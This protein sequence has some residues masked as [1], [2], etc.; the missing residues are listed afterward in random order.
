MSKK[1]VKTEE[2]KGTALKE[3]DLASPGGDIQAYINSV[4]S[5]G[6]LTPEEEKKLAEDLYYRNDL[7]AARKLVLAH[8]RFVI[9]IAKTYSG[10]G[11]SEADLIQEGNVG[12]MKAVRKFNPEAGVRVVSYAVH[13]IKAE[14]HEYVLKN[15]KIVKVATTKAQR[16]LFFNLRSK[17]KGLGWLTEQE[18]DSIS[19]DLGVKPEEVREMEKRLSGQDLSFDPL[20]DSDDDEVAYSPSHY[21]Q[22]ESS[23]PEE[24]F[25]KESIN[26][27]NTSTLHNAINELDDRSRDILQD[28]WLANKKLTLHDLAEKYEI[29]AERVRQIEKNAMKKVKK[30]LASR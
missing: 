1:E 15:W 14:I 22:D 4:H 12:L 24:I 13:W 26:E 11:L 8:L 30:S 17:K 6:I 7:D 3:M 19:K 2:K 16:K 27:E 9:Y 21:L 23:N 29:S 10:Y 28:R 5:I 18:I 20:T 25:E